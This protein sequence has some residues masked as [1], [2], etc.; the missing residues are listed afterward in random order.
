[1]LHHTNGTSAEYHY[2]A[3]AFINKN[4]KEVVIANA[5]TR[6]SDLYDLADDAML[7][8]GVYQKPTSS[9]LG[10]I[11][12]TFGILSSAF[13]AFSKVSK[14][15]ISRFTKLPTEIPT[16]MPAIKTFLDEVQD[17][18]KEGGGGDMLEYTLSSTGH[19]LGS[20]LSDLVIL[21]AQSRGIKVDKSITFDSPG[22][23]AVVENA[24]REG[25]FSGNKEV[26]TEKVEFHSYSTRSNPINNL[27]NKFGVEK[28]IVSPMEKAESAQVNKGGF[29]SSILNKGKEML[30]RGKEIMKEHSL[31]NFINA[32]GEDDDVKKELTV[33]GRNEE[34]GQKF[35]EYD[36]EIIQQM[37]IKPSGNSLAMH[38]D[39][40]SSSIDFNVVDVHYFGYS[41]LAHSIKPLGDIEDMD[42]DSSCSLHLSAASAA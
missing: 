19:S 33:E 13:D 6:P 5:G 37:D 14:F 34:T 10:S 26:D 25:V 23:V 41:D 24:T 27:N 42:A 39:L 12:G 29:F 1:M 20:V 17:K 11:P 28:I 38:K 15:A 30:N 31:S 18:L 8:A 4:T 7:G 22:S 3:V 32:L 36:K 35:V 21:E 40:Y 2:K 16:K 9:L